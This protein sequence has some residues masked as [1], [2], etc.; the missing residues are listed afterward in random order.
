MMEGHG[1]ARRC[2]ID[3]VETPASGAIVT[4]APLL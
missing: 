4:H 3:R 1:E 2:R